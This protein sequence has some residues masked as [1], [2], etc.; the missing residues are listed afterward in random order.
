MR[1]GKLFHSCLSP[2]KLKSMFLSMSFKALWDGRE[3]TGGGV[4]WVQV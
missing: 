2:A 4:L 1:D 3:A